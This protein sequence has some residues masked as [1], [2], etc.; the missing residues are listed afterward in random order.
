MLIGHQK[1]RE[2]LEKTAKSGKL[3]HAYL[4]SGQEKLGKK[5][6]ALELASFLIG[7]PQDK[8]KNHFS[9]LN[10]HYLTNN[11]PDFIFIEPKQPDSS[12]SLTAKK[13]IYI[14]QIKDLIKR[15]SLR[16]SLSKLKVAIIDNA[17]LMNQEAQTCLL[18]TLEEP[19]GKHFF[20]F[21]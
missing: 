19:K 18:K 4:F 14:L 17:H 20:S 15:I 21:N 11:H 7:L 3:P 13:E 10:S 6:L 2:F 16:P 5:T 8:N 12:K 9:P 1:Q